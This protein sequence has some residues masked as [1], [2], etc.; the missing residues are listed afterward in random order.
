MS[1]YK[2]HRWAWPESEEEKKEKK[3]EK[4]KIPRSEM[5]GVCPNCLR[6]KFRNS[7]KDNVWYQQCL[8]CD[9]FI[10]FDTGKVIRHG[11]KSV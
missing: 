4:T 8:I 1:R 5:P 2:R 6:G 3:E 9:R 10:E 7:I 11:N